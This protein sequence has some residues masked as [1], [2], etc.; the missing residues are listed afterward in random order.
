MELATEVHINRVN[1]CPCGETVIESYK[2]ADS[3]K[4][5]YQKE[6]LFVYLKGSKEQQEKLRI[7]QREL[8]DHFQKIWDL[9][10]RHLV[11][12]DFPLQILFFLVCC[13]DPGCCHPVCRAHEIVVVHVVGTT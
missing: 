13:F 8:Y 1:H 6:S 5:Q 4:K 12:K 11:R 9:R 2:G 7:E 10:N 3:S